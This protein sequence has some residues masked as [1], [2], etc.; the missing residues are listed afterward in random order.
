VEASPVLPQP[1]CR[2]PVP[3]VGGPPPLPG[4]EIPRPPPPPGT[5]ANTPTVFSGVP[6]PPPPAAPQPPIV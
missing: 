1:I 2:N 5:A 3:P 6:N 4:S